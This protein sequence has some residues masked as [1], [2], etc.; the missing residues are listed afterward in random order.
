MSPARRRR[1][2][3]PQPSISV[4]CRHRPE[5]LMRLMPLAQQLLAQQRIEPPP[6]ALEPA[7]AV[8]LAR[9]S[10][11][12]ATAR[13]LAAPR[14]L[15]SVAPTMM[16]RATASPARKSQ[17]MS[18]DSVTCSY[19]GPVADKVVI[20]TSQFD[21]F[22]VVSPKPHHQGLNRGIEIENQAARM[23][24]SYHALQP[25]KRR[26]AHA[27]RHRRDHMQTGRRIKYEIAGRQLDFVGTVDVLDHQFAAVIFVR[28]AEKQR[29]RQ[30]GPDAQSGQMIAP[31]RVID[32]NT[33]MVPIR[34][35]VPIEQRRKDLQRDRGRDELRIGCQ[36]R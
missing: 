27:S 36:R 3:A 24:I 28:F 32:V 23:C 22:R 30:I 33:E 31:H 26:N 9:E 35:G 16:S 6:M 34:G 7:A 17:Q 20:D 10:P 14:E 18:L 11:G 4:T 29:Y 15:F 21:R 1:D 8:L 12:L 25:E 2:R 13:E 19:F 5:L